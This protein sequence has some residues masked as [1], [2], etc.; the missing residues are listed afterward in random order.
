MGMSEPV[1]TVDARFSNEGAV[2]TP[3]SVTRESI[4]SAQL[5]WIATVRA[6]GRPHVTPLVAVWSGEALYFSTGTDEQKALNISHNAHV[7]L[8]TGCNEWEN[9]LDV[10]VE[11]E[12]SRVRTTDELTR[13]A[14]VWTHKWDGRWNYA[15]G[16]G[17][18]HH[19][20]GTDVLAGDI[21]VF[22]VT[23]TKILAFA[24]G[25]FSHTRHQ[26]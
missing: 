18:F 23:P 5:F 7:I 12:A 14:E 9:G 1:T 8:S 19:Q 3:W 13:V 6:D 21:F 4:E 17:V 20:D 16:D 15:V 22:R 26:F 24:K 10:V 25:A 11:G 2:A